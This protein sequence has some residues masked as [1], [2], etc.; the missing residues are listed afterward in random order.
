MEAEFLDALRQIRSGTLA[1]QFQV[2][3]SE[4]RLDYFS[5]NLQFDNG[6]AR[7]QLTYVPNQAACAGSPNSWLQM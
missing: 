2:P 3:E 5:V 1:C 7:Q 6:D 4:E